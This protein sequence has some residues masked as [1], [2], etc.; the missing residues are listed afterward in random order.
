LKTLLINPPFIKDYCRCQ[1]W[2]ARTRGRAICPPDWLCYAAA[3]LKEAGHDVELYDFIATG[4]DQAR[5]FGRSRL[6]PN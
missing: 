2:P 5:W 4:W 1:R 6:C 3:V